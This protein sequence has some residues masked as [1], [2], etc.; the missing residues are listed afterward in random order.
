MHDPA[1]LFWSHTVHAWLQGQY[2]GLSIED[3]LDVG[4]VI[5]SAKNHNT[6]TWHQNSLSSTGVARNQPLQPEYVLP[7]YLSHI[8]GPSSH[9]VFLFHPA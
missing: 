4:T 7:P 8:L 9:T 3:E 5:G 6:Q 2:F 1:H